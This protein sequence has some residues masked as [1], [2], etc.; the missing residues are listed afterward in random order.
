LTEEITKDD[1]IE[2]LEKRLVSLITVPLVEEDRREAATS[3]VNR[4]MQVFNEGL[5]A[6]KPDDKTEDEI[7]KVVSHLVGKILAILESLGLED[8]AYRSS[9]KLICAEIYGFRDEILLKDGEA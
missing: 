4:H 3:L 7:N 1:L 9:R 6:I 2:E 5:S 8:K